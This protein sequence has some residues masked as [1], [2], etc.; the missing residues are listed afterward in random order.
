M[1]AEDQDAA[2]QVL[3]NV[4]K[5]IAAYE[6]TLTPPRAPIDELAEIYIADP[7]D[8]AEWLDEQ[9]RRGLD[10]FTGDGQCNTCHLG[11]L[12]SNLEF[13][14][15]GLPLSDTLDADDLGRY[16]GIDLL[17]E[18]PFNAAGPYSDAPNGYKAQR[19]EQLIQ[20]T[21][22]LGQFKV[23]HLRELTHSAPY[24]HSGQLIPS[25]MW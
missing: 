9:T 18:S 16:S 5:N 24:M 1:A 20:S 14:N 21:E 12:G 23:P 10:L 3:V 15:I 2:T 13:H 25:A 11:L 4:A 6:A 8:A 7:Q 19:I 22:Q 17:Q